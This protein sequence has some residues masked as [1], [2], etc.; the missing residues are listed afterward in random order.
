LSTWRAD[1]AVSRLNRQPVGTPFHAGAELC[2]TFADLVEWQQET[3]GA[4]DPAI[5]RL[6]DAWDIHGDG[7]VPKAAEL[8]AARRTSGLHL[9]AFDRPACTITRRADVTLDVGAFGKGEALDRVEPEL[10]DAIWL[11]DLGGQVSV[12]GL[13][14]GEGSWTIDVAHPAQRTSAFLHL[15]IEEGSL[16]TSAGSE[17]DLHVNGRRVAHHLDPR[18]GEPA[19]FNGSVTVWHRRGIVADILS[20]ALFVMGPD[21][22]LRWAEARGLSAC[23]LVL[24]EADRVRARMTRAFSRLTS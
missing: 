1:S 5:G 12:H 8:A 15:R 24:D 18:T 3:G 19:Q 10:P 9:F 23:Y 6:I 4:F 22:G 20:T 17:R 7:R 16:S 13:P 14:A 2:R 11:I 21:D